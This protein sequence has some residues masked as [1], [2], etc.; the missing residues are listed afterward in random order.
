MAQEHKRVAVKATGCG[1]DPYL[2]KL[3]FIL[4]FIFPFL[5]VSRYNNLLNSAIQHAMPAEF[6][7]KLA[8]ECLNTEPHLPILLNAEYKK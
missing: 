1:F 4:K 5:L 6:G 8:A 2:R 3:N 7:E